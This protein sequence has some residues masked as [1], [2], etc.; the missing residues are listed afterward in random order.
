MASI[1]KGS[2]DKGKNFERKLA[3]I[4]KNKFGVE[5]KRTGSQ[6]RWKSHRGDVNAAAWENTILTDFHWECKNRQSWSIIDWYKKSNDD[7]Y[8]TNKKT[9]VVATKN[10]EDDYVFLTLND[11]LNILYELEGYRK[12]DN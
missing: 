7:N 2:Q 10:N 11:F 3:K 9:L 8:G 12:E 4:L 6:E 1:G 5:V